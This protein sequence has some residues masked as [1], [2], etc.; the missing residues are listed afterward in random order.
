MS[1]LMGLLAASALAQDAQSHAGAR[2]LMQLMPATARQT[3][4][5]NGIRYRGSRDLYEPEVNVSLGSRYYRE[6]LE[7]FDNNRILATAAYNAGPHRV[8]RWLEETGGQLPFDAWIETI[9]FRETRNYVQNVLAF[10]MVYA[11]HLENNARI[12][13]PQEKQR[14]L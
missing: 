11:H 8:Q 6:M 14:S 13:S 2:G 3:A 10:S 1:V 7:R 4:R 5:K 12:L 9:P